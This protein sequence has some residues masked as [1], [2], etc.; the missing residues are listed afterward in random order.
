MR[1]QVG[2]GT[3]VDFTTNYLA[4]NGRIIPIIGKFSINGS[5]QF[6]GIR[7]FSQGSGLLFIINLKSPTEPTVWGHGDTSNHNWV[8]IL[9]G[10]YSNTSFAWGNTNPACP[11]YIPRSPVKPCT[12][13][14]RVC[15]DFLCCRRCEHMRIPT[16][17][18]NPIINP[19]IHQ[20]GD[21]QK[22]PVTQLFSLQNSVASVRNLSCLPVTTVSNCLRI[23]CGI[24][25][26]VIFVHWVW[27]IIFSVVDFKI[28]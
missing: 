2:D 10:P 5:V 19:R 18:R 25:F 4:E 27:Y 14:H 15:D 21:D 22:G 24:Y 1:L 8:F 23:A 26:C 12:T 6:L 28:L 17:G 9:G 11:N 13:S 3:V 7:G 20:H 16:R